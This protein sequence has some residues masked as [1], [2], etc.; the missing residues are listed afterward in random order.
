MFQT[1]GMDEQSRRRVT[2]PTVTSSPI[3]LMNVLI[4]VFVCTNVL[5]YLRYIP[6]RIA[7]SYVKCLFNALRNCQ[8]V[9][10]SCC[11][12]YISTNMVWEFQ[13]F[14]ILTKNGIIIVLILVTF[15]VCVVV[16]WYI[17]VL[18]CTDLMVNDADHLFLFLL[19]FHI[20]YFVQCLFKS[21]VHFLDGNMQFSKL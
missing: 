5:I 16:L 3:P 13:L 21:L 9:F 14:R 8:P 20:S 17:A 7:G 6:T 1:Q 4:Q 19:T 10:Q 15:F 12:M 18:I 2:G 11:A